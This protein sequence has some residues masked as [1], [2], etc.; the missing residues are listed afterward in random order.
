[1]ENAKRSYVVVVPAAGVGKRMQSQ[2]PKQ[3]LT[4]DNFTIIEHT[5]IRLLSHEDI[6]KVVIALG[7]NDEYFADTSLINN[8]N[9]SIVVGGKERVDSVLAALKSIDKNQYQ[10]VL[11]HDAARPCITHRDISALIEKTQMIN[12]GGLLAMPVRDTMKRGNRKKQ[13]SLVEHTVER[14]ELWHALTPQMYRSDELQNAIEQALSTNTEITD[15]SSAM[16]IAGFESILVEGSG[17]NIKIT[18]P[19]DLALAEFILTKQK[20]KKQKLMTEINKRT[21]CE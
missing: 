13:Q 9:V 7:E 17:D 15:E 3:Y 4:I 21:R 12:T 5:V 19:D 6:D 1:M 20:I 16:E 2:C 14:S 10:W 11:V 8:S 18:R